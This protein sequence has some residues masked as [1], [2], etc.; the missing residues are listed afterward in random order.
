[1]LAWGVRN[2]VGVDEHPKT[3]GLFTVENSADQITRNG[4]DVHDSNPAEEL[5]YLGTL[6]NNASPNQGSNF[7]YPY[8]LSVW[9]VCVSFVIG[10]I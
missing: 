8:C 1:M 2:D 10:G 5:N 6:L 3:G 7:G 4:V 9:N